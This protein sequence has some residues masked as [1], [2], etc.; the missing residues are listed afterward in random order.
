MKKIGAVRQSLK[1]LKA[2][3]NRKYVH[4]DSHT[5]NIMKKS[6]KKLYALID[7]GLVKKAKKI[8]QRKEI[9]NFA[10]SLMM[11]THYPN[12]PEAKI[13][14]KLAKKL[15][16]FHDSRNPGSAI[17]KMTKEKDP[18]LIRQGFPYKDDDKPW[19]KEQVNNFLNS[20]GVK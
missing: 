8:D 4:G 18:S 1:G 20:F 5:G 15:E 16:P 11:H 3:H 2:L 9:R 19:T 17:G 13:L 14:P 10:N 7:Y 12:K 6:N